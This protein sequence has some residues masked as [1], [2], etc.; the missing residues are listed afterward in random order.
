MEADQ[1]WHAFVSLY[2]DNG[3]H[4]LHYLFRELP[5]VLYWVTKNPPFDGDRLLL[6]LRSHIEHIAVLI[7]HSH[8]IEMC[9]CLLY[10]VSVLCF[11]FHALPLLLSDAN[12]KRLFALRIVS[13]TCL[14][15]VAT[16]IKA[17][18]PKQ[19]SK[20]AATQKF[21][22]WKIG[23]FLNVWNLLQY[24][25]FLDCHARSGNHTF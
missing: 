2:L 6:L 5:D 12:S 9:A 8:R 21:I 17:A 24:W 22:L 18:I 14:A 7:M 13:M 16:I 15:C 10:A 1:M 3:T 19:A 23:P 4:N 25:S 11:R 20:S